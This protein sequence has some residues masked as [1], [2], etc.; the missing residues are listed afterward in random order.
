MPLS[1]IKLTPEVPGIASCLD[2]P[3]RHVGCH[4]GCV[5]NAIENIVAIISTSDARQRR[6]LEYDQKEITKKRYKRG[7]YE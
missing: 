5:E 7:L 4:R 1:R 2:C 6:Q 3:R